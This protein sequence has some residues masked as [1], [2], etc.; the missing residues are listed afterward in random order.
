MHK[1]IIFSIVIVVSLT[2]CYRTVDSSNGVAVVNAF[3]GDVFFPE[4]REFVPYPEKEDMRGGYDYLSGY[5][6]SFSDYATTPSG[7]NIHTSVRIDYDI[8]LYSVSISPTDAHVSEV[9]ENESTDY[10]TPERSDIVEQIIDELR[11]G[12]EKVTISMYDMA[13][14]ELASGTAYTNDA[15]GILDADN[16]VSS[17]QMHGSFE[18]NP[19]FVDDAAYISAS[20][21]F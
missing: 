9:L 17:I 19:R 15:T 20:F 8:V 5:E 16:I 14:F 2:G 12:R 11:N 10:Y 4:T 1:L 18:I 21:T 3:N 6:Y 13:A 7:F